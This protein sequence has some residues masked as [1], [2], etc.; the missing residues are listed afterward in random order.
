MK[1]LL[2]SQEDKAH[3]TRMSIGVGAIMDLPGGEELLNK[4]GIDTSNPQFPMMAA[5]SLNTVAPMSGGQITD[6][7]LAC[8]EEGLQAL[9]P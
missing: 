4:C 6:E 8:I 5:M 2:F 7:M 1:H 3:M 9:Q